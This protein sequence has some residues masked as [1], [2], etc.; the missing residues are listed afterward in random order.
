MIGNEAEAVKTFKQI[1]P[2]SAMNW[3]G[4][5]LDLPEYLPEH[6]VGQFVW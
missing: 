6:L 2:A 3:F 5:G 1:A 4:T